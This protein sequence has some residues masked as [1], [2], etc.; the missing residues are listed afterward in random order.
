MYKNRYNNVY[1]FEQCGE[2]VFRVCGELKYWRYGG[3]EYQVGIDFND[4]GFADPSGGP[5]FCQN[6]E[7]PVG[8]VKR[9]F[10]EDT[11]EDTQVMLE[12]W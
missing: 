10:V 4:L 9:V 7:L 3:K 5:F 12:M 11:Q 6:Q 1:W 2:K 8:K